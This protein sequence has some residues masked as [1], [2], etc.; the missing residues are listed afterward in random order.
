MKA[1]ILLPQTGDSATRD[2]IPYIAKEAEREG[3]NSVW[4]LDRLLWPLKPKTPYAET[5]DGSLPVEYQNVFDPLETLT[6]L[7]GNTNQISL[8]TC[9]I[10]MLFHNP[11]VL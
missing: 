7:A 4:V 6:C 11:V 2:N 9:I 3:F 10:D 5:P 1:G 8:G